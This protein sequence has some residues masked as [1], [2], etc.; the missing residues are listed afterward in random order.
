MAHQRCEGSSPV[1]ITWLVRPRFLLFSPRRL[2]LVDERRRKAGICTRIPQNPS[3]SCL[4]NMGAANGRGR[5]TSGRR[6]M[7]RVSSLLCQERRVAVAWRKKQQLPQ[8]STEY[9]KR[10]KEFTLMVI[11]TYAAAFSIRGASTPRFGS[12]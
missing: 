8:V 11:P 10:M 7:T 6:N 3:Y 5:S 12:H 2:L 9:N 1:C 4:G